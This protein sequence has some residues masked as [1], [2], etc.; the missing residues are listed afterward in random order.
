MATEKA[1]KLKRHQI[2]LHEGDYALVQNMY[3]RDTAAIIR[4]LVRKFVRD[5]IENKDSA[6]PAKE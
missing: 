6:K 5:N 2:L 3:G 4:G 1:V